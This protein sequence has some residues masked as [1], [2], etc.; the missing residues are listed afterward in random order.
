MR[1]QKR[2]AD[3]GKNDMVIFYAPEDDSFTVGAKEVGVSVDSFKQELNAVFAEAVAANV[4][5]EIEDTELMRRLLEKLKVDPP[6]DKHTEEAMNRALYA[7]AATTV[8][9]FQNRNGMSEAQEGL[10]VQPCH[11]S[12]DDQ[13]DFER[14]MWGDWP[15]ESHE[16]PGGNASE[17]VGGEQKARGEEARVHVEAG[18]GEAGVEK[19]VD[20]E[21]ECTLWRYIYGIS[22]AMT[23]LDRAERLDSCTITDDAA[24]DVL[25]NMIHDPST[26]KRDADKLRQLEKQERKLRMQVAAKLP[27]LMPVIR[28]ILD[29]YCDRPTEM[30]HKQE[31]EQDILRIE[32]DQSVRKKAAQEL[33]EEMESLRNG[34]KRA[35]QALDYT[36]KWPKIQSSI[37]ECKKQFPDERE[38]SLKASVKDAKSKIEEMDAALEKTRSW[39]NALQESWKLLDD[40]NQEYKQDAENFKAL[41]IEWK[42][43]WDEWNDFKTSLVT[44][45]FMLAFSSV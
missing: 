17:G 10:E 8:L 18:A 41:V 28:D 20:E 12:D 22:N 39:Y 30:I 42:A 36:E 2:C 11:D 19:R 3:A 27:T 7:A 31:M 37:E 5:S 43:K 38:D 45:A 32:R 33:E 25:S 40:K 1:E 13:G 15:A 9:C 34:K 21:S 4:G 44:P 16:E 35:I 29:G 23:A 14:Q 24:S 6:L 26:V